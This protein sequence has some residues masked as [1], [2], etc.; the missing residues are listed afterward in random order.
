MLATLGASIGAFS[1]EQRFVGVPAL[2]EGVWSLCFCF[3]G[4]WQQQLLCGIDAG[5]P[6][7]FS[8][9]WGRSQQLAPIMQHHPLGKTSRK[10]HKIARGRMNS[11]ISAMLGRMDGKINQACV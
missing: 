3:V 6:G 2:G 11:A 8:V 7:R 9:G 10:L 5:A 4:G 1:H